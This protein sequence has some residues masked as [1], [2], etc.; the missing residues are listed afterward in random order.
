MPCFDVTITMKHNNT[1]CIYAFLHSVC[2]SNQFR[3]NAICE[4]SDGILDIIMTTLYY[5]LFLA[6]VI[7]CCMSV[8]NYCIAS[9]R[10]LQI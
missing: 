8:A 10:L 3:V 5:I 1:P 4:I 9:L 7:T 2:V 6:I